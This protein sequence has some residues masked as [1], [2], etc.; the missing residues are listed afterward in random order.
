MRTGRKNK[1]SQLSK[2]FGVRVGV[3]DRVEPADIFRTVTARQRTFEM[4]LGEDNV[5]HYLPDTSS[6]EKTDMDPIKEESDGC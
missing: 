6:G 2:K 3:A 4:A 1:P 5:W